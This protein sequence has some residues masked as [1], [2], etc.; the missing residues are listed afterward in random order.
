MTN[1]DLALSILDEIRAMR[2]RMDKIE[3]LLREEIKLKDSSKGCSIA[4]LLDLSPLLRTVILDLTK[5][6]NATLSDLSKKTNED[7]ETMKCR[8]ESLKNM[9]YVNEAVINGEKR[10]FAVIARKKPSTLPMNIW[11]VLEERIR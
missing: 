6:E 7:E 9:G 8:L 10:Y 11:S 4:N 5:M 1:D 3:T 2:E